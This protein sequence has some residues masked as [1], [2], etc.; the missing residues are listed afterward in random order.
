MFG[1]LNLFV[2]SLVY[3]IILSLILRIQHN[4]FFMMVMCWFWSLKC[5]CCSTWAVQILCLIINLSPMQNT[6]LSSCNNKAS[7]SIHIWALEVIQRAQTKVLI[8]WL[9]CITL[10][11][12]CWRQASTTASF[13]LN[14]DLACD[15]WQGE[16]AFIKFYVMTT[17]AE[18]VFKTLQDTVSLENMI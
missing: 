4:F 14:E 8:G 1:Q 17:F 3:A 11:G 10:W 13:R 15:M 7:V 9:S 18:S 12:C 5:H 16:A 2:I 6:C